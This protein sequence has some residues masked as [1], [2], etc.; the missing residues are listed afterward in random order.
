MANKDGVKHHYI[1]KFYLKQWAGKDGRVCEFS[2]PYQRE[3]GRVAPVKPPV[4][5]RRV[6]PDGTGYERGL[7]SF[8]RLNSQ[9]A[10]FLEHRFFRV[11]DDA[12]SIAVGLLNRDVV[13]FTDRRPLARFI[14]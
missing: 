10:D 7:Y 11:I 4:R 5:A 14:M 2:R 9:L 8:P 12:A 6:Y 13:D 1:P 3:P